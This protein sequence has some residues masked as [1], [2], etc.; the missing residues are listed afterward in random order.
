MTNA[1]I[2]E[3]TISSQQAAEVTGFDLQF[4]DDAAY[5]FVGGGIMVS[6]L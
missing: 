4:V 5:E 2:N 3:V 6:S 1:T